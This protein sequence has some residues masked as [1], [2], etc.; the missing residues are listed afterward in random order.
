MTNNIHYREMVLLIHGL[1]GSKLDM[2]PLQRKLSR[3]GYQTCNWSYRSLGLPIET[4]ASRLVEKLCELLNDDSLDRLHLVGHS[5]GGIILRAALSDE[6][7]NSQHQSKFGRLVMLAS[8][9]GG[10]HVATKLKPFL[11]WAYPSLGQLSDQP[12]SYVN[13]LPNSPAARQLEFGIVE[14]TKDRVI[15]PHALEL[16]GRTDYARVN[17]HHGVLTWYAQTFKFVE[18]FLENGRFDQDIEKKA[19][20]INEHSGGTVGV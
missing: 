2:W 1:V 10:S 6:R 16:A 17:G 8:P 3:A 12:D 15:H 14:A 7:L 9:N 5:M 19:C 18:A 20:G 13:Q 11:S 4:H